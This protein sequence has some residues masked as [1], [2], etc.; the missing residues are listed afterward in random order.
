MQTTIVVSRVFQPI[1]GSL[2][3]F[4]AISATF[5]ADV[6]RM[7]PQ[8]AVEAKKILAGTD[9][10]GGLIVH[11][12]CG[13]GRLTAAL[14]TGG[15][16]V[17]HGLDA[18]AKN[19]EAAREYIR[20]LGL[21][22]KVSVDVFDGRYLPYADNLV[23]LVVM[24]DAGYEIRDEEIQR[25]LAPGGVAVTLDSQLSTLDSFRKPW[26]DD[27]D[28]WTHFL[29]D[30]SGNAVST[31]RR[32]GPPQRLQWDG[33]PR[34]SRSHE[35][36]MSVTAAVTS[37]GRIFHTLDDGPIG[38]HETAQAKRQLPDKCSL[39]ARDAFNGIVLW[40][41]PIPGW[42]SAAWD[43]SRWKWGTRDQLWSS[44]L[45][46]PR[47]LVAAGDRIYVTL[48][49]R[50]CVSELDAG[51]GKTLREF[52]ETNAAEEIVLSQN[53]LVAR[54]RND[55]AS[56]DGGESIVAVDIESGNILWRE[57]TKRVA[58]L[59]LGVS[60][61]RVCFHNTRTLV[62]VDLRTGKQL[63]QAEHPRQPQPKPKPKR[64]TTAATLVMTKD[65]V[66]FAGPSGVEARGAADGK[67][68]WSAKTNTSFRGMP[69]VFVIGGMAW[70][71]TLTTT[72][73]DLLT[74]QVARQIDPG[75]LYT[76]GHHVRCYRG[77]ATEDYLLWSKRGIE[78]VDLKSHG[79]MRHDWVRGMCR[80]GIIP[81]NGLIYAPPHPCFCY[82]GVKLTG[83][84]ALA[85]GKES[86]GRKVERSKIDTD[87]RLEHGPAYEETANRQLAI[88]NPHDWPTYRHD[89]AR[90]G[91]AGTQVPPQLKPA[92]QTELAGKVSPP[93]VA[94]D[95]LFVAEVEAHSVTCLDARDG[96]RLWSYTAGGRVDSPPTI[97]R[98]RVVFGC[99]D[100]TV[101]CLRASDGEL[102]WRF[103]AAPVDRRIMSYGRIESAWPVH[104][105][106]L[107]EK[108][109]VYFAAGRSSYLDGGIYMYGLDVATGEVRHRA[110]LD[111][112]RPD[113]S[114][115]CGRAHEMDG[116]RN[117][118][119]VSNGDRLFL[120]QNV[121]D[122]ELKQHEAPKIAKWGARKT[123]LH[124]VATGGFLDDSGF[125][126]LFWMYAQRWPGLYVAAGAS[127][128]GQILVFDETT[129]YGLHTFTTKFSRSP[130]FAPGTDGYELFADD[131]ANE[132]VLPDAQARR[133]RGSM[134]RTH[135]PKWSVQIPVR[136]RAMVVAGEILFFAGPPDIIEKDDP[137][138]AFEGRKGGQLWAVSTTD[139][140]KIAE[141][142][143]DAPPAFDGL[144]A[145]Q[146]K[147]Y[148]T[149]TDGRVSCWE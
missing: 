8:Y 40:K 77:K 14:H 24:R 63:W 59:T 37:G 65:A 86:K 16:S 96:T 25:V 116:S 33:G 140:R 48:G 123:D 71:G 95:H 58:D 10:N 11:L 1:L 3:T 49:F 6:T 62:A 15:E 110:H 115:P 32:V 18:D 142:E 137:Y 92:W 67:L 26:P 118:I 102:V 43:G 108:N 74:G 45:T 122:L 105:S 143:L 50:A 117:D 69:D 104:G 60:N 134:S 136:A 44:P 9:F 109:I 131:N 101:Y 4:L 34:W 39:V 64:E 111:G 124:L 12:G 35:T 19:A 119:L 36:D 31:D 70:L 107:I 138:G 84:N 103:R 78:F 112:P 114:I 42:G 23:N 30:A 130:Y 76:G 7:V 55:A 145:A 98:G 66:V 5:A 2:L 144:I 41:R 54:V 73:L 126:R 57:H 89:N 149:T 93:V 87:R 99:T 113:L 13:D 148:V 72:G 85:A 17:V 56:T 61:G 139:G 28:E 52:P 125:D 94:G 47:R 81:A 27:I 106:V 51:T 128:A 147:L 97:H 129:T 91:C 46:L 80:Y 88:E 120:T 21:Y 22:G 90:S 127:K 79:H 68:L 83:F 141:Y 135:P 29:H 133:E 100:G 38:I 132:P 121:F 82:P 20:S 75:P 146:K 53:I